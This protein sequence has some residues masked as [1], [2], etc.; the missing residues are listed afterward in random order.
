MKNRT[1]R[2]LGIAAIALALAACG[3]K[4]KSDAADSGGGSMLADAGDGTQTIEDA[5]GGLVDKPVDGSV[6]SGNK[7]DG[8]G[9]GTEKDAGG[10]GGGGADC[11]GVN[12]S[13]TFE[14]TMSSGDLE[15]DPAALEGFD[16]DNI[17]VQYIAGLD[18]TQVSWGNQNE[19]TL[20]QVNL[21]YGEVKTGDVFDIGA[22]ET[23]KKRA[24]GNITDSM[25]GASGLRQWTASGG[26][27]TI[28][29]LDGTTIE[30]TV[31]LDL[32]PNSI[33]FPMTKGTLS[34][35]AVLKSECYK[36]S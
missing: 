29:K 18:A 28:D 5:G 35:K 34:I 25:N 27:V 9:G 1:M 22:P 24:V 3:D 33:A 20:G 19:T 13:G 16:L 23:G 7:D 21:Y 26:S 8:G 10:G 14:V 36:K 15:L 2:W 4:K 12:G 6:V 17:T 30:A 32:M 31:E 11:L